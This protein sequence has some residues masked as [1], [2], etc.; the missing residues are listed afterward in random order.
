MS[1]TL[2]QARQ[3]LYKYVSPSLDTYLVTEKINSALERIYNSGK[4]KG[5]LANVS[6]NSGNLPNQWWVSESVPYVTLPRF[7]QSML[8][9]QY[10]S[11]SYAGIPRLIFPQWQEYTASGT[12][13][14]TSGLGMQM[15]M[16]MGD[17]FSVQYDPTA[18]FYPQFAITN[19]AD[20]G[21]V[22]TF[23]GLDE[24]GNILY[25]GNGN[26][27]ISVTLDTTPVTFNTVAVG[28]I[29]GFQ[30]PITVGSVNLSAVN[31]LNSSQVAAISQYDPTELVPSYK[32]Y[33]LSGADN[34]QLLN[35]LLKR[36]Y[37]PFVNGSDDNAVVIPGNEGALKL[38]LM[39][40]QYEDKNDI[41]RA[42]EY[43]N[44]AIQLLNAEL[45][46]DIGN[47]II[48]LQMNPLGG[49]MNIP[50]RY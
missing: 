4:W 32:R 5:M 14:I 26:S 19:S 11:A 18:P 38:T 16:D 24:Y 27:S 50:A 48:T 43:F 13:Q 35:M 34:A 2:N 37:V 21:T 10:A 31:A 23:Q 40:L 22:V 25:D 15:A 20:A 7:Y 9:I 30:K 28:K 12:G 42:E 6:F 3:K 44:K 39:A 47:P 49:A 1:L 41:E 8:G 17:G 33:R 45:K 46:E 29:T 36:R